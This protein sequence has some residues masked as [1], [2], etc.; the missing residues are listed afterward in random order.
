MTSSGCR[1]CPPEEIISPLRNVAILLITLV[2]SLFW[3]WYSWSPFFPSIGAF[4]SRK[5]ILIYKKFMST[6]SGKSS[7]IFGLILQALDTIQQLRPLQYFKLFVSYLQVMS[8][9]LGFH[10]TWPASI[11]SV[12]MWCKVIFNFNVLSLPGV[13]CLWK[14]IAYNSKLMVYTLVPLVLAIMLW[15]PVLV[16]SVL[17]Y[18]RQTPVDNQISIVVHDRFWNAI[19]FTCFMVFKFSIHVLALVLFLNFLNCAAVSFAIKHYIRAI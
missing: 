19:M 11:A 18:A 6:S 3:F 15:M 9:F 4:L 5:V 13:S 1:E 14:G 8:S 7:K 10:V 2:A 17:K 16:L 12:M